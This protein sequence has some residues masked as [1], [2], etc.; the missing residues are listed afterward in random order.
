MASRIVRFSVGRPTDRSPA[1]PRGRRDRRS[2]VALRAPRFALDLADSGRSWARDSRGRGGSGRHGQLR[3][4]RGRCGH[5]RAGVAPGAAATG[6]LE[7]CSADESSAGL[8]RVR[9][10]RVLPNSSPNRASASSS[11]VGD[12][13][14]ASLEAPKLVVVPVPARDD[15]A[16]ATGTLGKPAA[17]S[18]RAMRSAERCAA[19]RAKGTRANASSATLFQR[20]SRSFSRQRSSTCCRACGRSGRSSWIGRGGSCKIMPHS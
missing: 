1:R 14:F 10:S 16:T 4:D 8:L 6:V 20:R 18:T 17:P 15:A 5:C 11:A 19:G 13:F 7:G 12:L 9:K 3:L 2:T